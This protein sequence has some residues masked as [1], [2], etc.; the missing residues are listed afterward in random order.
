MRIHV[1]VLDRTSFNKTKTDSTNNSAVRQRDRITY[2]PVSSLLLNMFRYMVQWMWQC[3][4]NMRSRLYETAKRP[5]VCLPRHSAAARRCDGFAAVGPVARR[6]RSTDCCSAFC[7]QQI[8]NASSV[9][10]S[11]DVVLSWTQTYYAFP[12]IIAIDSV[13]Q[14]CTVCACM[15][16]A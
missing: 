8:A 12:L 15:C 13:L 1:Y 10:L 4:H 16:R 5:S 6:Y 11:A 9:M 3:S 14:Y 2:C 7:Q